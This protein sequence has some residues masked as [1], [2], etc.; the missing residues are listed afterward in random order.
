MGSV[1]AAVV[2]NDL[3]ILAAAEAGNNGGGIGNETP[4]IDKDNADNVAAVGSKEDYLVFLSQRSVDKP[5][6]RVTGD[7][8]LIPSLKFAGALM[9][10][11]LYSNDLL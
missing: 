5:K 4:T 8:V 7:T 6:E 3:A 2:G 1:V 10:V 11:F 9:L